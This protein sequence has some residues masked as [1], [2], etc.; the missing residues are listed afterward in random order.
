VTV[1]AYVAEL[2]G[3][4]PRLGRRRI[5]KEVEAHLEDASRRHQSEGL[6]REEAEAAA[7]RDFG[8]VT[9]VARGL[10]AEVAVRETRIAPLL[11]LGATAFFVFPLYVVP[12]N[13]LPP[14][15]WATK[16]QDV[17]VLQ[18]ATIALWLAAGALAA[19]SSL[20]AW[21]R[22]SRFASPVLQLGFGALTAS[23][24]ASLVLAVRWVVTVPDAYVWPLLA[25]PLALGCLAACAQAAGWAHSRRC[26]LV[27][28]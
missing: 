11:A 19:A 14:A 16:P 6:P 9:V 28:D 7:I 8:D 27:Q 26:R 18:V 22:W 10:A 1:A 25:G 15:E 5:L 20:L 23:V 24:V 17:L 21:T 4:L 13:T 12:E 3:R 2:A